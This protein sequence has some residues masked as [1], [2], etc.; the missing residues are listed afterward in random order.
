MII[1]ATTTIGMVL[2]HRPEALEA[3]VSISPRFEKLRNPLLRKLMAGRTSLAMAAKMGG[4][5]V[6]EFYRRLEPLD[7]EIAIL[8]TPVNAQK[9]SIP[10][11]IVSLK[12]EDIIGLDVRP[13]IDSGKDPLNLVIKK[14]QAIKTGQVLKIINSFEPLPLIL[15]LEKKGFTSYTETINEQHTE[16]YF[17][18][19]QGN[20]EKTFAISI[21]HNKGWDEITGMFK[22]HIQ[23]IDV[24]ALEMPLPMITILDALNNLPAE[25]ALFVYHQRI[26]VFLLPELAE[27]G[28][29]YRISE[30]A[31]GEV[32]LLIFKN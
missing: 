2:K 24:R 25:T 26:P 13:V 4:V 16:T 31:D 6:N 1:N 21:D 23:T 20:L 15:L 8:P 17:Y 28:F 29:Y 11:F 7:F 9:I 10:D 3:I 27:R 19:E 14:L 32:H 22:D 12:P 18:R 5:N 30:I